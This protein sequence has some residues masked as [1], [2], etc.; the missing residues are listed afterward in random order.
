MIVKSYHIDL[1]DFAAWCKINHTIDG[2]YLHQYLKAKGICKQETLQDVLI[3][4]HIEN[5]SMSNM[6][7]LDKYKEGVGK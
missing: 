4:F 1:E 7:L 3:G 2:F 5:K 6:I